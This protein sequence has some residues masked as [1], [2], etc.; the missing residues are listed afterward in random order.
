VTIVEI[1]DYTRNEILDDT[2][3]PY[4]WTNSY[5]LKHLNRAYEEL[6][7]ETLCLVDST[8]TAVCQI[9]LL[10]NL[11][12]HTYHA[13]IIQIFDMRRNSDG[14]PI[15]PKSEHFM[16]Y[17][18]SNWRSLT[19]I[20]LYRIMDTQNRSFTVYP[21]YDSTGYIAGSSNITFTAATKII[22][23][24]G[25][26]F[27][28]HFETGDSI[29]IT[30]T[31]NNNGTFTITNVAA[32]EIT[33]SETV[34]NENNTSAVIR[35][36]RE[37]AILRVARLPLVSWT[38]ADFN[39]GTATPEIDATYH[40]GLADGIAKLA[41]RK[42]DTQTYDPNKAKEHEKKF[43]EFKSDVRYDIRM[44]MEGDNVFTPSYGAI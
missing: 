35:K 29:V 43:E 31:T 37:T 28:D 20:P 21:K 22:S 3:Q 10:S 34:V 24:A 17:L 5:L 13:K 30:G 6:C 11:G 23:Q 41:L 9:K 14:A 36:V 42:Q 40:V 12:L 32:T 15:M 8:T 4:L 27:T 7:R 44:L 25:A 1:L 26:T 39:T 33:V 38:D 2:V 16:M 19:G 18:T